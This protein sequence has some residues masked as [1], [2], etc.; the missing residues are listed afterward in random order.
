MASESNFI[1][2]NARRSFTQ[3]GFKNFDEATIIQV[4]ITQI[5]DL[6]AEQ[7]LICIYMPLRPV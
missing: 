4:H 5:H 3:V 7:H 6:Q 2:Q 1:R